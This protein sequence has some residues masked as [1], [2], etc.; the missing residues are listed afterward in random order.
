MLWRISLLDTA[1]IEPRD[2]RTSISMV[3]VPLKMPVVRGT[4]DTYEKIEICINVVR[5]ACVSRAS[6]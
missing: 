1:F 2:D 3:Y 6:E 5:Y 4:P